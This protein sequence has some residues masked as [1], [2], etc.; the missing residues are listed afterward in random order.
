MLLLWTSLECL[1]AAAR[2]QCPLRGTFFLI[3]FFRQASETDNGLGFAGRYCWSRSGKK[4]EVCGKTIST[5]E[6][7][8]SWSDLT[9][10]KQ[11]SGVE[12]VLAG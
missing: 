8:G 9:D 10:K 4:L 12:A 2:E 11:Q 3:Y 5:C 6:T 7:R 1:G